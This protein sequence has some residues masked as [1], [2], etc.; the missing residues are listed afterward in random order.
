[1]P[2][3]LKSGHLISRHSPSEGAS[4]PDAVIAVLGYHS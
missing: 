3:V 2:K 1:M 4:A